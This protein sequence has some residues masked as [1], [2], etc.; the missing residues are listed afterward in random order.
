VQILNFEWW[1]RFAMIFIY[2]LSFLV[3]LSTNGF[4]VFSL[5][6]DT[7]SVSFGAGLNPDSSP[8]YKTPALT[9]T[10]KSD[11]NSWSLKT[12]ASGAITSN[13]KSTTI[14]IGQLA[15]KGGDWATYTSLVTTP[16]IQVETGGIGTFNLTIDY[17]L[18][19][20]WTN[21]AA[22]DYAVNVWYTL[23]GE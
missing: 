17:R 2:F 18:N 11:L 9:A 5:Q 7:S 6:L 3:L 23:T 13:L 19:L 15:F 22:D 21:I 20:S 16:A 10:V 1:D 8:F 14:P 4:G 12:F